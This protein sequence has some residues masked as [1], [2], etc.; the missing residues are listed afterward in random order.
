MVTPDPV[1]N[2]ESERRMGELE[3]ALVCF[4]H[5]APLRDTKKFVEFTRALPR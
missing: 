5:G 2:R 3:P 4:G 1:R